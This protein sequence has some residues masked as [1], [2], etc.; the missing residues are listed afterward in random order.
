MQL[1]GLLLVSSDVAVIGALDSSLPGVRHA[2]EAGL[3]GVGDAVGF[4]GGRLQLVHGVPYLV[5]G[6]EV[7]TLVEAVSCF[8]E[9]SSGGC[10]M[11]GE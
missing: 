6:G 2:F 11:L 7:V 1:P 8:A 10:L 5:T 3:V 9:V 4:C